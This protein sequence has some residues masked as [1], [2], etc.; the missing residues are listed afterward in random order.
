VVTSGHV[1]KNGGHIIRS[2]ITESRMLHSSF[3]VVFFRREFRVFCYCGH[4]FD[5]MTIYKLDRYPLKTYPQTKT[6]LST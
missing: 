2:A 1:E 6:E 5:Q 3:T 4:Y